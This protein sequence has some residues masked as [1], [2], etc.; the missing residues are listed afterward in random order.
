MERVK[1]Y[2]KIHPV[3]DSTNSP[4]LE[5]V[6]I[7]QW[8]GQQY[9]KAKENKFTRFLL[10][11]RSVLFSS[12]NDSGPYLDP[13]FIVIESL[14]PNQIFQL[15]E[16]F[17]NE[18]KY[19]WVWNDIAKYIRKHW[20]DDKIELYVNEIIGYLIDLPNTEKYWFFEFLPLLGETGEAQILYLIS[21]VN[22][23]GKSTELLYGI[24][25]MEPENLWKFYPK[26]LLAVEYA[27]SFDL[28]NQYFENFKI[29]EKLYVNGYNIFNDKNLI[30]FWKEPTNA[31]NKKLI[32]NK[33]SYYFTKN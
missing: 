25:L 11:L 21:Y 7:S 2:A 6:E 10:K 4:K 13:N 31:H 8:I 16:M 28:W 19:S 5:L 29:I 24:Y 33:L 9:L 15:I 26:F 1:P 20:T 17:I 23:Q 12:I 14:L 22:L 3:T 27:S 18:K 30:E 32:E